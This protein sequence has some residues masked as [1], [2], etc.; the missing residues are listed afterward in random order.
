MF[1]F[2]CIS[3]GFEKVQI[4][5]EKF[6]F[7][8]RSFLRNRPDMPQKNLGISQIQPNLV[9]FQDKPLLKMEFLKNYMEFVKTVKK[10]SNVWP[11]GRTYILN[12]GD[13]IYLWFSRFFGDKK[14]FFCYKD[15]NCKIEVDKGTTTNVINTDITITNV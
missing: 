9:I 10:N 7:L 3:N 15:F 6:Y 5:F 14:C 13:W 2:Y 4:V 1:L 12:Y 11:L 8:E